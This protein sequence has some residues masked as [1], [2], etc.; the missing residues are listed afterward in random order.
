MKS[1]KSLAHR[2]H[3]DWTTV[4][5]LQGCSTGFHGVKIWLTPAPC[6]RS[7]RKARKKTFGFTRNQKQETRN[8]TLKRDTL[9][10]WVMGPTMELQPKAGHV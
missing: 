2:V 3:R 6:S 4:Q 9:G 5:P 8:Y 7:S 1:D 10:S